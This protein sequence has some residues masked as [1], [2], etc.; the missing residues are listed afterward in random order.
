M[1]TDANDRCADC[2]VWFGKY[3]G[4]A[5]V[6]TPGTIFVVKLCAACAQARRESKEDSLSKG[7]L[8]PAKETPDGS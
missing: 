8:P 7:P 5:G 1:T 2:G 3:S 4:W 6:I